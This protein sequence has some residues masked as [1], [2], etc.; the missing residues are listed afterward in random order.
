MSAFQALGPFISTFANPET[1]GLYC[2]QDGVVNFCDV[3]PSHQKTYSPSNLNDEPERVEKPSENTVYV[4]V[5]FC[6]PILLV[7][8]FS[9]FVP[10]TCFSNCY[11]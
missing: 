4:N 10:T 7:V 6:S 2:D 5:L 11:N 1:T 9:L 3:S 8:Y